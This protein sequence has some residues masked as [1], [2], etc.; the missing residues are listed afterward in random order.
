MIG[1]MVGA[2]EVGNID[3]F[4]VNVKAADGTVVEHKPG[5]LSKGSL[6]TRKFQHGAYQA[7]EKATMTDKCDPMFWLSLPI[8]VTSHKLLQYLISARLAFLL[9]FERTIPHSCFIQL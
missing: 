6:P 8:L 2:I 9:C 7:H 4:L 5:S 3:L 1:Q